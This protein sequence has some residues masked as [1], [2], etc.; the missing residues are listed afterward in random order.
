M[1]SDMIMDFHGQLVAGVL[2]WDKRLKSEYIFG[3]M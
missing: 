1:H 3:T 2:L